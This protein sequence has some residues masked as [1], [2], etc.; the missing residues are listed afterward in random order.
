MPIS[1][2]SMFFCVWN[3]Y[4][5]L[6]FHSLFNIF[7]IDSSEFN[8]DAPFHFP[9]LATGEKSTHLMSIFTYSYIMFNL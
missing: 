5:V 8:I 7:T 9:S 4:S 1:L 3:K 2:Y 6:E